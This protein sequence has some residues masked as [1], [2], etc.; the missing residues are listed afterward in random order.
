MEW[1]SG[2]LMTKIGIGIGIVLVLIIVAAIWR[3][4]V[5]RSRRREKEYERG[6]KMV[7]M[8]IHLPPITDDVEAGGRDERSVTEEEVSAAVGMYNILA[9]TI[10]K[11]S[12]YKM[13]GQRHMSF[14]VIAKDGEIEFYVFVPVSLV[15]VA[16]QAVAAA[17]PTARLEAIEEPNIFNSDINNLV[18]GE[19]NLQKEY[20]YP[21]ETYMDS[22]VDGMLALLNALN[23]VQQGDGA[24]VQI[25]FRPADSKWQKESKET[26]KTI[27]EGKE[28]KKSGGGGPGYFLQALSALWKPPEATEKETT[29]TTLSTEKT[30]EIKAIDEKMRYVGFETLIRVLA[31]SEQR[32]RS[33]EIISGVVA[34]FSQFNS[35][36][37]NGF[38][39]DMLKDM[40]KM[41]TDYMLRV[42]PAVDDRN[43]LNSVELASIFHLPSARVI[44]TASVEKQSF[45]Q[46][47]GPRVL[48]ERGVLLGVN[49]FRGVTKEIRIDT[50]DRRR[51]IYM[52][53]G[54]GVGK[55]GFLHNV[56][57][58]DIMDGRG[59]AFLDPHGDA[60]ETL[61]SMMPEER[62]D[63]VVY[64][65]PGNL[66]SP[67]GMN[68]FEYETED[69]KDFIIS[70]G[71]NMLYSLYDPGHTGIVGPRMEHIFRNAAL[72]LMSDPAGATFID[73][74]RVLVDEE[75]MKSKLRYVT[76]KNVYDYWTKEWPA[77]MKSNDSGELVT[78][79]VSKWGP[80]ISNTMMRNILGQAQSGFNIRK[81]MDEGKILLVNLSKGKMGELN[82]K[83]L[84]M[85]LVMKFQAAAMSRADTPEEERRDF[86][87]FVD[88]FQNFSTDSFESILSEARKYRLSLLVANQFIS[89]L[90]DRI[91]EAILGNIGSI[92][93]GRIGITDAELLA[94]KFQPTFEAE[95]LAKLPNYQAVASVMINNMPS[96]PFS[97]KLL[98]PMG[99]GS[100]QLYEAIRKYVAAKYGRARVEVD[101]E[102]TAR[103]TV[104]VVDAPRVVAQEGVEDDFMRGWKVKKGIL[105]P[106]AGVATAVSDASVV[107]G[108]SGEMVYAPTT[109]VERGGSTDA[110]DI[111]K[112]GE[113]VP[114]E[115]EGASGT[116]FGGLDDANV[117][118]NIGNTAQNGLETEA[119]PDEVVVKIR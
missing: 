80:F 67:I 62:I 73:I 34:V 119:E 14:E 33:E 47:D 38:Q 54:T 52:I 101:R 35:A 82:S 26:T 69:Q 93:S 74:P 70:E 24:A 42:F 116:V 76:D 46:V 15:S 50:V 57:Y 8:L 115:P 90:T 85:I 20:I 43:I 13:Y 25:L 55:T 16:N 89:Q 45:K 63:D 32:S 17:Y 114:S 79:V 78:W 64:F 29:E 113:R 28:V 99:Q 3:A 9:S 18:G 27:R 61:L 1:L 60:V 59:L 96:A 37:N 88:E 98:P 94:K 51:H 71:I 41:A 75:F 21:I 58:Q 19:L 53:G 30:E 49:E 72:L 10:S 102:I 31:S 66:D 97:M 77:S 110:T 106:E 36:V 11:D 65:D 4:S 117:N 111:Q 107:A 105:E 40:D 118:E 44:P 84:G 87:L 68:M 95:D 56:A 23:L 22:K 39:Y 83:L 48:P 112:E 2:G 7:P 92:I 12:K 91:R 5:V 104:K 100:P 81:I 86:C 103:T 109:S 6:M 108:E